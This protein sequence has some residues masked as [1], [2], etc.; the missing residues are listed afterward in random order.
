MRILYKVKVLLYNYCKWRTNMNTKTTLKLL[1]A[2]TALWIIVALL[3]TILLIIT[4]KHYGGPL[5]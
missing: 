5:C 2:L 1:Y 3:C 4:I